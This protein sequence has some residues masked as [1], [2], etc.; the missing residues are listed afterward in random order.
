VTSDGHVALRAAITPIARV[1]LEPG[2]VS[3]E[4]GI[5]PSLTPHE[6][7]AAFKLDAPKHIIKALPGMMHF[8]RP[9]F[10]VGS[11][12][13]VGARPEGWLHAGRLAHALAAVRVPAVKTSAYLRSV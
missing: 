13:R 2:S 7:Q 3:P 4:L 10:I 11:F 8:A 5:S 6:A 9:S 12:P 1:A